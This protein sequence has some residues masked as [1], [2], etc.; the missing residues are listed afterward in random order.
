MIWVSARNNPKESLEKIQSV[1]MSNFNYG[2]RCTVYGTD[3]LIGVVRKFSDIIFIQN[4]ENAFGK[5]KVEPARFS[6]VTTKN[7]LVKLAYNRQSE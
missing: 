6:K 2:C 3:V 4:G 1:I 7:M 5:M